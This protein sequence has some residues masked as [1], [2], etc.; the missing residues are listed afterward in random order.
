MAALHLSLVDAEQQLRFAE[1]QEEEAD[2]MLLLAQRD[3]EEMR[4]RN[5]QLREENA[6]LRQRLTPK[7]SVRRDLAENAG[8]ADVYDWVCEIGN[9]SD[10]A[11]EGWAVHFSQPFLSSLSE[12]ER[13]LVMGTEEELALSREVD[14]SGDV[15]GQSRDGAVR[16]VRGSIAFPQEE[17]EEEEEAEE[18]VRG[19]GWDG[20]V[21]AVLGLFDKG[22]T[23]VL[24]HLTESQLPS[25]KKVSTKGLSFKHVRVE[26][27]KFIVLDSEGS[28]APVKV[29]N[30]RSVVEKEMSEHFIRDVIFQLA[31]YFL[32]VVN[33]FTSLDQRYLDKL[34]RNLQN[35]KRKV[36]K[37]VIVVHNCKTVMEQSVL[38]Y[39]FQS[40]VT[41]VY[42]RGRLHSTR[43]AAVNPSTEQLEERDV[44]WF[45]TDSSR[46]VLLA[47][48]DCELGEQTNPWVFAL[49]KFW[50]KAVFV[51]VNRKISVLQS[52]LQSCNLRLSSYFKAHPDLTITNT[53][54]PLV[55]KIRTRRRTESDEH[56]SS[57]M[58]LQQTSVDASGLMLTRPNSFVPAVDIVKE[59]TYTVYMD[60]PG[61]TKEDIR[62]S[63]QNVTTIVKGCRMPPYP[64]MQVQKLVKLE[65]KYGEFTQAFKVPQEYERKWHSVEVRN[66]VLKITFRPD[67]DEESLAIE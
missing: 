21:V 44:Q 56:K 50:L 18:A 51:P 57:S 61:M 14:A 17:E 32:C 49:L 65:R 20:A 24:N 2:A 60:V 52:V 31:D 34:T 35:S 59:K 8:F 22:K 48:E 41:H 4:A 6:L 43:V 63:R 1:R 16:A 25:G 7:R 37:E 39:I 23:F 15:E 11:S 5:L 46:H 55:K 13:R 67:T 12:E 30:D 62:L 29:E 10:V 19:V 42:G 3:A 54:D 40:Q 26:G 36:F 64:E 45:K 53:E 58:R 9:L 66:G 47:N 27:T 38:E 33:D 28:Y